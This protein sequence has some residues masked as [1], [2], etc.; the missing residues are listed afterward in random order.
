MFCAAYFLSALSATAYAAPAQT[1]YVQQAQTAYVAA[2][3]A[4]QTYEAYQTSHGAQQ[5][6]Y[7]TVG[8]RTQVVVSTLNRF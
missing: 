4:A 5:Y 3:R 2:P 8:T 1:A 7:G 6:T